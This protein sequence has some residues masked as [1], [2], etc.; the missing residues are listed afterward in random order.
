[1]RKMKG[2]TILVL[3]LMLLL[4]ACGGGNNGNNEATTPPASD[5]T[6]A[7]AVE[8]TE[9]PTAEPIDMGGRVIKAAAWWDL[10]PAGNTASEKARLD[11]IAEVEKKYNVKFEFVNVPFEEYMPK[12]TASVLG[13]EPF[14]DIV[15]MEYKSA[16]P[17]IL[18]GQLLKVSEF[19]TA[20]NNINNEANLLWKTAPIAGE[21]YGFDNPG[22]GGVGLH[23]NRDLF[24]KLGLPDPKELYESGQWNWDK[25]LE[26][27]KQATKD[28]DNDGKID[29]YGFS[30]WALDVFRN[31][32]YANGGFVVDESAKTQG[33]TDP[34]TIE[35]AEFVNRMYNVD[36][37]V[38]IKGSNKTAWDE[39]NT[40]KDGDVAMFITAAWNLGGLTF[41][42]GVVPMPTGPQGD[43]S[44]TFADNAASGKF[45]PKG[46][47]DA[48][49]VYQVWEETFDIPQTEDFPSQEWLEGIYTHEDDI[50]ITRDHIN[51]TGKVLLDDSFPEFPTGLFVEDI[52]VGN[53][54]VT[55]TAE[56]V[57]PLAEAS[58]GKLGQ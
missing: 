29:T 6:N 38:R 12:F 25:F 53:Q 43:P 21:E 30:G 23:Y 3:G 49:L 48:Q 27:A 4:T 50:L 42:L 20:A 13:G 55:A 54:S 40:F 35:A 52:I 7:P 15:Q 2:F 51:G 1:M 41:D 16:L 36:K 22:T 39:Y 46:V 31:F 58:I 28:N 5:A 11:K 32:T 19:T 9:A 8:A 33:F 57:K 47:K 26:V 17:A 10:K 18:K 34:K 37:V 45:I 24:Q 44:I 56:K 14:A